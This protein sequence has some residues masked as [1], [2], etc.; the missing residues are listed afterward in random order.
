[1]ITSILPQMCNFPH[2]QQTWWHARGQ[3]KT[4]V[5]Q[6][7]ASWARRQS[8]TTCTCPTWTHEY[9]VLSRLSQLSTDFYL[10]G[11]RFFEKL[12]IENWKTW[13]KTKKEILFYKGFVRGLVPAIVWASRASRTRAQPWSL[14]TA[15]R[16]CASA[17]RAWSPPRSRGTAAA[18]A[19]PCWPR[20]PSA[21]SSRGTLAGARSLRTHNYT[22]RTFASSFP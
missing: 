15:A 17:C 20:R 14:C 5:I 21:P 22:D 2:T 1:M 16:V 6:V 9:E 19:T 13:T 11:I 18:R 10:I 7:K 12:L 8:L 3:G 4:A